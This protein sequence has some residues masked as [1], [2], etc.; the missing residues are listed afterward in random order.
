[1]VGMFEKFVPT[2]VKKYANLAPQFKEAVAAYHKEVKAGD[3]PDE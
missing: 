1:M 2:F 3:F